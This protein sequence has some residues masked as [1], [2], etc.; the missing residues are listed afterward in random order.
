MQFTSYAYNERDPDT[1][2]CQEEPTIIGA[3][4]VD[5][6]IEANGLNDNTLTYSFEWLLK[7]I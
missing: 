4:F 5:S 2:P 7:L 6:Y 1:K 3:A